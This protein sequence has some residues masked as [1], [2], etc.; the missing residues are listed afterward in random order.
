MGGEAQRRAVGDVVGLAGAPALDG[1]DDRA[2]RVHEVDPRQDAAP[3]VGDGKLPLAQHRDDAVGTA[4]AVEETE[5]QR[6]ALQSLGLE[7]EP[8]LGAHRRDVPFQL[9]GGAGRS[10]GDVL[11]DDLVAVVAVSVP[12]DH[13]LRDE[14]PCA[15]RA[16]G[17]DEMCGA[18]RAQRVGR[19]H[20]PVPQGCLAQGGRG[21]DDRV[22]VPA[23]D[24]PQQRVAVHQIGADAVAGAPAETGDVV[25]GFGQGPGDVPAENAARAG[26]EDALVRRH[27]RA[28]NGA[29]RNVTSLG[30]AHP[31]GPRTSPSGHGASVPGAPQSAYTYGVVVVS[32]WKPSRARTGR[33]WPEASTWT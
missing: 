1:R 23:V 13:R 8:F 21:V 29:C 5:A 33:L 14:P 15:G 22:E 32:G 17:L 3:V 19:V 28:T 31:H 27:A 10:E 26:Q 6:D 2:R 7:H 24:G 20:V 9:R 11:G 12:E 16:R 18:F 30:A 4:G 25:A